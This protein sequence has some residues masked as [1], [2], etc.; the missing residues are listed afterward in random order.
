[1]DTRTS[2][3]WIEHLDIR[4]FKRLQGEFDFSPQL[5]IVAGANEAGK[6][7][8]H[9][10][11][12]RTLFGFSRSERRRYEGQST[13]T[14]CQPWNGNPF[15]IN[16]VVHANGNRFRV[17]WDFVEHAVTLVDADSGED[18][19]NEVR[20]KG[21]DVTL[22]DFLLKLGLDDFR[23]ACCLS[24]AEVAA[25][26]KSE[27]LVVALQRAVELGA[28][29]AGVEVAVEHLNDC[30][31]SEIGVRVDSLQPNPAGRLRGLKDRGQAL[32]GT[33]DEAEATERQVA[34]IEQRRLG[35][36]DV[37]R[38]T[39]QELHVVEQALLRNEEA[40]L[41]ERL[42]RA[43]EHRERAEVA[44]PAEEALDEDEN[45]EIISLLG[46]LDRLR[47]QLDGLAPQAEV[48]EGG[49]RK[50]EEHRV[51]LQT[52][53]D[54]LEAYGEVD[55]S[56]EAR[57]LELTGRQ[58]E[59]AETVS[60]RAGGGETAD[61]KP[62]GG[63]ATLY[64]LLA[65]VIAIG[66]VGAGV[67]VTPV[68]FAGLI[69][70]GVLAYLATRP[71]PEPRAPS[72][73]RRSD[74]ATRRGQLE[75][76][77]SHALDQVGAQPVA[78]I[79]E[80][81]TAYL[82][83]CEK[84]KR[85]LELRAEMGQLQGEITA[86]GGPMKVKIGFER[87]ESEIS[88]EL[89]ARYRSLGIDV[90]DMDQAQ[91]EFERRSE[92]ANE[93]SKKQAAAQEAEEGYRT[94]LGELSLEELAQEGEGAHK[95]L[96]AHIAE[97]GELG[98]ELAEAGDLVKRRNGLAEKRNELN[99][100]IAELGA[101]ITDREARVSDIPAARE[102]AGTITEQ[103]S[104]LEQAA[105]AVAI[106][107]DALQ[108]A[109]REAHRA[110]RPHL[111]RALDEHLA[112]ITNDR[113]SE[114]EIDDELHITVV[115]PETGRMVPAEELSRGTQDQ[116]FFVER[117]EIADLLD[118]TTGEAP[119][120]LDEPF[121]HFDEPRLSAGLDLLAQEAEERQVVLFTTHAEVAEQARTAR[122]DA[123]LLE[124]QAP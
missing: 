8:M 29:D 3:V 72:G 62:P 82:T 53:L 89:A 15:R 85:W 42:R 51:S 118:P 38:T 44:V 50:L 58:A 6:S 13:L 27:S 108:E 11:L 12:L 107:R 123:V 7:T 1:M 88:S 112:E 20:A 119:L 36:Q 34:E 63:N 96:E 40:T 43:E 30:L 80:R 104:R 48:A 10:A 24:Q 106:A 84:H 49:V 14:R 33:I 109:A 87:R 117:L 39:E 60:A 77:L 47:D 19:S 35:S 91:H 5:T 74:A 21:D 32:I 59:V 98:L 25:V 55:A 99:V 124:L 78:D 18:R 45:R 64:W 122:P 52:E 93:L 115:A 102:E 22:G 105:Q 17:E 56:V 101:Q 70:A 86:A 23:Q 113:Y 67:A 73:D 66:S 28:T 37:C 46:E 75:H 31:R 81:A 71:R 110:F 121:V 97:H 26:V 65:A 69:V 95:E 116:I 9:E 92:R 90:S 103:V 76:D 94:A 54:T 68:A 16:A 120:L 111:K 83:A 41:S 79:D 61:L 2:F 57:V 100:E 4:G 114:V